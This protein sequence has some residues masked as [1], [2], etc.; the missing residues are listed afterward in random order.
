M[1]NVNSPAARPAE[2]LA[3]LISELNIAGS[4]L[5]LVARALPAHGL[6]ADAVFNHVGIAKPT[7][8][9]PTERISFEQFGALIEHIVRLSGDPCIGMK[10]FAGLKAA[11]LS[12][13]GFAMSCSTSLLSAAV[14]L[15]RF[16]PYAISSGHFDI[17]EEENDILFVIESLEDPIGKTEKFSLVLE[18]FVSGTVALMME[19][20]GKESSFQHI[21]LQRCS[22]PAIAPYLEHFAKCQLVV[23]APFDGFKLTRTVMDAP[24]PSANPE[25]AMLNDELLTSQLNVIFRQNI[26]YR[27]EQL[28]VAGLESGKFNKADIARELAM[29]ERTLHQKLE[30]KGTTFSDIVTRIRR[31]LA[32]QYVKAG[33][34]R[35][36]Q[37]AYKLGFTS[38]SNFS[39]SFKEWTGC[40]PNEFRNL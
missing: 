13:L 4:F 26:V 12:A 5:G 32:M 22:S 23:N 16:L 19:I 18:C 27:V 3:G 31:S 37:I 36:N 38:A 29:S 35:I 15:H 40:T 10:I 1:N 2:D 30:E 21:Y 9:K 20:T 28:V 33:E 39:R 17:V 14:R 34:L 11:D 7:V 8:N 6:D 25:M 24:L